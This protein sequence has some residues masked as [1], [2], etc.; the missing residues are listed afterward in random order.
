LDAVGSCGGAAC[1]LP[2]LMDGYWLGE[3]QFDVSLAVQRLLILLIA[4]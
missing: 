3:V 4:L 1:F 2:F